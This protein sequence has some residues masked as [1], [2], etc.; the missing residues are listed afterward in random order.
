MQADSPVTIDHHLDDKPPAGP[1]DGQIFKIISGTGD[2]RRDQLAEGI[3][4]DS[5]GTG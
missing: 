5:E 1:G 3:N 4:I 2:C